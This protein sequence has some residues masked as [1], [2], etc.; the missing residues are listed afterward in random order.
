V[1]LSRDEVLRL[2]QL[3][4]RWKRTVSDVIRS[5]ISNH[6]KAETPVRP[7]QQIADLIGSVTGLPADL[8]ATTGEQLAELVRAN[9]KTRK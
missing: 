6:I 7:Y 8:A 9:A 1:R 5:A 2:R 4:K 3:A